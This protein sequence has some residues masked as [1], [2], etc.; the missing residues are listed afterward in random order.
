MKLVVVYSKNT[1]GDKFLSPKVIDNSV[2]GNLLPQRFNLILFLVMFFVKTLTK[3]TTLTI[4]GSEINSLKL[5][6]S[7]A[8]E[9]SNKAG[10]AVDL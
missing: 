1:V 2:N 7:K 10:G 3:P 4:L 8:S 6:H 9:L 5:D